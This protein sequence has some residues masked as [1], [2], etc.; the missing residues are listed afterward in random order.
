MKRITFF[1]LILSLSLE[2]VEV[3]RSEVI[4]NA[5]M[6]SY[7]GW[8]VNSPNEKY[9]IYSQPGRSIVGEAYSYRR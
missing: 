4:G 3:T 5:S 6:F 7:L 1:F 8:I 9:W 2:G